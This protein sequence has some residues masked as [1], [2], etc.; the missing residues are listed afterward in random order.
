MTDGVVTKNRR[1]NPFA[2]NMRH[3]LTVAGAVLQI[4]VSACI[5]HGENSGEPAV[6][7]QRSSAR[8]LVLEQIRDKLGNQPGAR[9][10]VS[11]VRWHTEHS[12]AVSGLGYLWGEFQPDV[13]SGP[14]AGV[15]ATRGD[16]VVSLVG[17][18]AWSRI[19]ADW[20]PRDTLETVSACLELIRFGGHGANVM[21]SAWVLRAENVAQAFAS[22]AQADGV[23][24]RLRTDNG[25]VRNEN[26]SWTVDVWVRERRPR[27]YPFAMKYHCDFPAE[28]EGQPTVTATDSVPGE[29]PAYGPIL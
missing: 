24:A 26:G 14:V 29:A 8:R 9:V 27:F 6:A 3:L 5:S 20:S 19:A 11:T 18:S 13:P 4:S 28:R 16:S 12:R 15:A 17:A 25:R 21:D 22:R 23:S 7:L 1:C 10:D 2:A